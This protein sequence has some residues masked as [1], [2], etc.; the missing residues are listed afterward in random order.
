MHE[1]E[2]Y[3]RLLGLQAPWTV[4]DVK[5]DLEAG[6]VDIHVEHTEGTKFCCPKCVSRSCVLRPRY[7]TS[8]RCK[9]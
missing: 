6:Q 2:F 4:A 3:Q 5:L 1:T 9:D 7:S 8:R